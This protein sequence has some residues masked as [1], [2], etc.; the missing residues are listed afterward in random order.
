MTTKQ[1]ALIWLQPGQ[2]FPPVQYAW[3]PTTDVPGLLCAGGDLS[4]ET[5]QLAYS[6]GIF[7]W[8]SDGQPLLWWSPDPRMV[9]R[10][11]SLRLHPSFKKCLKRFVR[12]PQCEIRVDYAFEDVIAACAD[13]SR[14]GQRSTWIVPTMIDAYTQLHRAGLAHSVETWIDGQ[15]S[16]GLYLVALGQAVFGESMFYHAPDTSKIA[17]AALVAMCRQFGITHIDCQQNTR[18]LASLGATEMPRSQFVNLMRM[19]AT[20]AG[21]EWLFTPVYWKHILAP[22]LAPS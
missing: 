13:S 9:L 2:V 18:H 17:L 4:V 7:P 19:A 1:Q 6:N 21:P 8:F 15:L 20:L 16:G 3:G 14:H 5:L 10:V 11:D 12:S 22:H